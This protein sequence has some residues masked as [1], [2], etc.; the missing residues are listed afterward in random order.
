MF[1]NPIIATR[2]GALV[3]S[4]KDGKNG[5]LVAPEDAVAF[6]NAMQSL[7]FDDN[8]MSTLKRG[9]EMYG[10]GDEYDWHIIAQQTLP[11]LLETNN[12]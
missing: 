5:I 8:L 4:I 3:E 7:I 10:N 2:V 1:G 11:I 6:A 12:S 9:A